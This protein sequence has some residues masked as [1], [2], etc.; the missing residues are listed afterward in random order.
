MK[1]P[2]ASFVE[3]ENAPLLPK[4]GTERVRIRGRD[5]PV[6]VDFDPCGDPDNPLEWPAPFK[7][8]IV[9]MLAFSSFTVCVS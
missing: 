9:V 6:T 1:S 3:E 5:L 2:R 4:A 8:G 7:W